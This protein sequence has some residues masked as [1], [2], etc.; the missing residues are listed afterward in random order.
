MKEFILKQDQLNIICESIPKNIVLLLQG[1]LASGKTTLV[2]NIVSY[3]GFKDEVNSPTF[4]IM[5]EYKKDDFSIFHYDIYQDGIDGILKNGLFENLFIK[6]LHIVE[7]GDE[8][9]KNY[10]DKYKINNMIIK[11]INLNDKR[12]YEIYE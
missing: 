11:I 9:L 6:A 12:K 1:D 5:Q 10:L 3:F 4:S 2:K 8:K 7:W